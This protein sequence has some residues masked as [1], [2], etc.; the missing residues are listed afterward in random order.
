[1]SA[2]SQRRRSMC[3]RP[4]AI[5]LSCGSTPMSVTGRGHKR[6]RM[7]GSKHR[8]S[9]GRRRSLHLRSDTTAG[10]SFTYCNHGPDELRVE[11]PDWGRTG[12][13]HSEEGAFGVTA[14]RSV[15]LTP[16]VIAVGEA[17]PRCGLVR[18]LLWLCPSTA[19]L[20]P[21]ASR[22]CFTRGTR[23]WCRPVFSFCTYR[24]PSYGALSSAMSTTRT[25]A[26]HRVGLT[27]HSHAA[28]SR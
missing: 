1:M 22:C 21:F 26:S 16:P 24:A 19:L 14:E 13:V 12:P 25:R 18:R 27:E 3:C 4:P 23:G 28:P 9:V 10:L 7:V 5:R 6:M 2:A 15:K 20:E 11:A 17:G 8:L